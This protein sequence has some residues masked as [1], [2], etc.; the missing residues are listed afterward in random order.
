VGQQPCLLHSI[1]PLL[2]LLLLLLLS[3]SSAHVALP[4]ASGNTTM[5]CCASIRVLNRLLYAPG[6]P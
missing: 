6:A 2:L 4:V 3:S 5:G 1:P